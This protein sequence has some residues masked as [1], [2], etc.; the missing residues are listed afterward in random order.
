MADAGGSWGYLNQGTLSIYKSKY[1]ANNTSKT[2][3][4]AQQ[5]Q[6]KSPQK[7]KSPI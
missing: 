4:I 5:K 2:K 7:I 3:K 6:K 1:K